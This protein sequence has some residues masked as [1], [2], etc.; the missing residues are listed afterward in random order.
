[1]AGAPPV[2]RVGLVAP[3]SP[4]VGG[5]ATFADWL[6]AHEEAIGC[7]FDVFELERD[8][9]DE[10]GGRLRAGS[11]PRQIRLLERFRR[12]VAD[13]PPVVHYCVS[14]SATGLARDVVFVDR[15]RRAGR[16]TIAHVHVS[17]EPSG[18][19]KPLARRVARRVS[20]RVTISPWCQAALGRAGIE[21]DCIFNPL[22]LEPAE[23]PPPPAGGPLRLVFVG[24]Y[25]ERKGCPQLVE[26]LGRA[27]D[28]G[29]DA[30][31][32]FVGKERRRGEEERLRR[33][34]SRYA[35]ED[36]VEWA[37]VAARADVASFYE[38]ADVVCLPSRAEGVPMTLLEG[39]ALG[40]P[41]LATTVGGIPDLVDE[42]S[43]V[44]VR[45]GDVPALAD[46]IAA[47]ARDPDG[48]R[49]MGEAARRRATRLADPVA[50]AAAWRETYAA[51][52]AA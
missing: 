16:R 44:L 7:R 11:V 19:R 32:T 9:E 21:A 49:R 50:V 3:L 30:R 2:P 17:A 10:A 14:W 39:M 12:W 40:L 42:E 27:R 29:V 48:R 33:L 15:L 38:R 13:A 20:A 51:C 1:M 41:V 37:G 8:P 24:A 4:Q 52:L 34:V 26:A 18:L 43:G 23:T 22:P 28:L 35:L 46:A 6:L 5:V 25:G 45:P 31:L 36:R 47:L